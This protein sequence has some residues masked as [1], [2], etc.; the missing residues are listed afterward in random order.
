MAGKSAFGC[1]VGYHVHRRTRHVPMTFDWRRSL[2]LQ[3]K[4]IGLSIGV[5][6]GKKACVFTDGSR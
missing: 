3:S 4:V 6:G 1:Y 2:R 5:V